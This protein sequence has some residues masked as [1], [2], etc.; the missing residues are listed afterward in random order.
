MQPTV[1]S[2]DPAGVRPQLVVV[3]P[4]RNRVA[5]EADDTALVGIDG[6]GQG[7]ERAVE[8]ARQLLCATVRAVSLEQRF[9]QAEE[10]GEIG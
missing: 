5:R 1:E 10:A 9:G 6:R 3:E 8:R 2:S 7:V 4:G